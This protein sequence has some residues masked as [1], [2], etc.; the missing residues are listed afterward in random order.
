MQVNQ[1]GIN[2]SLKIFLYSPFINSQEYTILEKMG[3]QVTNHCYL[4][5]TKKETALLEI[6]NA[7]IIIFDA[8]NHPDFCIKK[9]IYYSTAIELNKEIWVIS[10]T[11]K[12]IHSI[13]KDWTQVYSELHPV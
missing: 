13:F 6:N 7:D 9:W 12:S 5:K 3:H 1:Q 2:K 4:F 10:E 8:T 11:L